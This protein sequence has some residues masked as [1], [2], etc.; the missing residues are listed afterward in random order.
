ME[1]NRL[2]EI[3][4]ERNITLNDDEKRDIIQFAELDKENGRMIVDTLLANVFWKG[5]KLF[6]ELMHF[7]AKQED[8]TFMADILTKYQCT[9]RDWRNEVSSLLKHK[10]VNAVI[11]EK[12]WKDNNKRE[13]NSEDLMKLKDNLE[14]ANCKAFHNEINE[15]IE[16]EEKREKEEAEEE[17]NSDF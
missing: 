6:S 15:K 13:W 11:L 4:R 12:F 2:C 8:A 14:K 10:N 3:I 16:K 7:A 1:T 5:G 17:A 9:G